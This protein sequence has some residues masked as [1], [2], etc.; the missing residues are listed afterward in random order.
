MPI[1][2]LTVYLCNLNGMGGGLT[3]SFSRLPFRTGYLRFT[4]AYRLP[5]QPALRTVACAARI[6]FSCNTF[7]PVLTAKCK[8]N[9]ILD[10]TNKIN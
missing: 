9:L 6:F 4:Q 10:E 5:V 7:P 2:I 3:I 8:T 1:N